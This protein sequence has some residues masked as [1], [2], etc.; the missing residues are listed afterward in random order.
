MDA[1]WELI[2]HHSRWFSC[3][4]N[5]FCALVESFSF[6]LFSNWFLQEENHFNCSTETYKP[7]LV[8]NVRLK[9]PLFDK[10]HTKRTSHCL[11]ALKRIKHSSIG[12][13]PTGER[14]HTH[15][16]ATIRHGNHT[17]SH[18]HK[19][20]DTERH[21]QRG[22]DGE[23]SHRSHLESVSRAYTSQYMGSGAL[24]L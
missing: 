5:E 8:S 20:I 22:E 24:L 11:I 1:I 7:K 18:T 16:H 14:T 23:K 21:T 13:W 6:L 17:L 12:K 2:A 4:V 19:Q 3:M 15:T 9:T 10:K